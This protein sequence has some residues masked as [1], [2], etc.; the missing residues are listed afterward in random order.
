M[1]HV[2]IIIAWQTVHGNSFVA[3]STDFYDLLT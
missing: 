1:K 3:N 2:C